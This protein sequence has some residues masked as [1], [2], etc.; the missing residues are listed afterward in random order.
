VAGTAAA[1]TPPSAPVTGS[2]ARAA[3]A[4]P[5]APARQDFLYVYFDEGSTT[6][7]PTDARVLDQA[8]RTFR[9]GQPIVMILTGSTDTVGPAIANLGL[10]QRRANAV[11]QALIARGIPASRF[12]VLAKGETDPAVPDPPDTPQPRDRR[13]E[14]AWR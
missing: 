14:I 13:V 2:A 3:P 1:Q 11:L 4:S 6:I 5:A 8:A 7:R 9:E 12:Q 10:S